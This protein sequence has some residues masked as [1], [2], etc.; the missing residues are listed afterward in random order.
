MTKFP[1]REKLNKIISFFKKKDLSAL[2]EASQ[3]N[4][5]KVN[6]LQKLNPYRPEL[7]DLFNI[8]QIIVKNKRITSL[9]FGSGW[10]SL[11]IALALRENKKKF[12]NHVKRLR[13]NNVFKNYAVDNE[14]KFLE[15]SKKRLK[16][17]D[18]NLLKDNYFL[19]SK[20]KLTTHDMRYVTEFEKLPKI[21]PDF[22]Y[23]DGPDQFKIISKH[24]FN[25]NH[26]DFAPMSADIL[27]IEFFLNPGTIMLVDGRGLN[28]N[29]LKKYLKRNWSYKYIKFSD[30]HI[31]TLNQDIKGVH[32]QKLFDF[33]KKN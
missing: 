12:N 28:C 8:Y 17:F 1:K 10:S 19:F 31:F 32:S 24:K 18:N 33:F 3:E 14:K 20:A 22:I 27:K 30:Q 23:L 15:I 2:L 25:I 9:E 29:F 7:V 21:N 6:E 11:I 13:R 5:L 4:K 26:K 16:Q